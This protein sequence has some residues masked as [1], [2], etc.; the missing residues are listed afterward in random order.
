M[1]ADWWKPRKKLC[2]KLDRSTGLFSRVIVFNCI[3]IVA[4]GEKKY[5]VRLQIQKKDKFLALM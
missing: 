5:L 3:Y 1:G 4:K 2:S